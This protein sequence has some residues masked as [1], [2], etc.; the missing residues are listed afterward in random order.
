MKERVWTLRPGGTVGEVSAR[1]S[2]LPGRY[3]APR[4]V[5]RAAWARST[6]PTTACSGAASLSGCSWSRSRRTRSC[7]GF[8]REALAAA[9]LSGEPHVVTIFDVGDHDGRPFTVMEYLPGGTLAERARS[10]P[11]APEQ[12]ISWLYQA[13][14]ALDGAHARGVVHR[15]VKPA[16]MFFRRLGP[17]ADGRLRDRSVR[18]LRGVQPRAD[19]GGARPLPGGAS[20]PPALEAAAGEPGGDQGGE[21]PLPPGHN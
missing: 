11:T 20:T 13:A 4:L 14:A 7:G 5:G 3:E 18:G 19:A 17:A 21:A 6:S 2:I 10:R 12:A 8:R 15:D 1:T 9:R 16:N